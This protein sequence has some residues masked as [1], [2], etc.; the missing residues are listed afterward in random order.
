MTLASSAAISDFSN[1]I[2]KS[3]ES[4]L[5]TTTLVKIRAARIKL[6]PLQIERT[7][8]PAFGILLSPCNAD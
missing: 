2:A 7:I 8:E 3:G 1:T 4:A 6:I 5:K